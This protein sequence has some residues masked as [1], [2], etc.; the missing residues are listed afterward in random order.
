MFLQLILWRISN[1]CCKE[2]KLLDFRSIGAEENVHVITF[3]NDYYDRWILNKNKRDLN[4][5]FKLETFLKQSLKCTKENLIE[6]FQIN[7]I[8]CQF[9]PTFFF[10][11]LSS[12]HHN[13]FNTILLHRPSHKNRTRK[14]KKLHKTLNEAE[15]KTS[16]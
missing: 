15:I 7:L 6:W 14:F 9:S 11:F 8:N 4:E 12:V 13:Y 3:I 2:S 16:C 1:Y 10:L 5:G